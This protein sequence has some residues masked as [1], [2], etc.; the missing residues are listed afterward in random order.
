MFC[1]RCLAELQPGQGSFYVV[2][3][4]AVCD[5]T[6]PQL[7]DLDP[8]ELRRQW[9]AALDAANRLSAQEALDSVRRVL[10]IHLCQN[11]YG[12]WIEDPVGRSL[13]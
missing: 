11:C 4:E 12:E 3:I 9:Q 1:A 6:P 7:E 5:P 8:A 2:R 10:T 13:Q